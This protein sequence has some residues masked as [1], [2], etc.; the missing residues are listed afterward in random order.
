VGMDMDIADGLLFWTDR[1]DLTIQRWDI[2]YFCIYI[3]FSW[4]L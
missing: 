4:I 2:F 3:S 1:R